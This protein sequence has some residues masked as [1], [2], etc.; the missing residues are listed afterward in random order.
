MA[1]HSI[2]SGGSVS[3]SSRPWGATIPGVHL[4]PTLRGSRVLLRPVE[5]GDRAA[6][7]AILGEPEVAR[8]WVH[9]DLETAVAGLY[10]DEDEVRL[11]I[12]SDGAVAGMKIG[13]AHV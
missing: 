3:L 6:L 5:A 10:D 13:R 9:D 7:A 8:W 12:E 2:R 4:T 11:T 1:T